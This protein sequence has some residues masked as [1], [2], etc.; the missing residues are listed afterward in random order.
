MAVLEIPELQAQ[1]DEDQAEIKDATGQVDRTQEELDRVAGAAKRGR[2]GIHPAQPGRQRTDRGWWRNRRWTTGR[3][4]TSPPQ[5]QVAAA[6]AAL[7]IRTKPACAGAGQTASR[8]GAVRL[9][10]N[11]RSLH[12]R[13]H[14]ALR[15]PGH[16][17][18]VRYRLQHAGS[19]AGAAFPGRSIPAGDSV[20]ES[21][22]PYIRIG[23][24]VD[25][26]VPSL[27][28]SFPGQVARFSVDVEQ[29]TRTMHTEVDVPNPNGV[30][31][32]G[33]YAEA[34]LKVAE[35]NRAITVPPEA[36]NIDGDSRSVWVVDPS[37]RVE[38]RTV[39]LGVETPDDVEVLSG[40]RKA[41]WSRWAIAARCGLVSWSGR[42]W[43][44]WSATRARRV[45]SKSKA[46]VNP[47]NA[48]PCLNSPFVTPTSSSSSA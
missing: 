33:M 14:Q 19:A 44:S 26:R 4:R 46:G 2:S 18:A 31:L 7:A 16:V 37:G 25:V 39:I 34:T 10:Q 35:R 6:R 21:Y 48:K 43:C 45:R 40:L 47:R 22:V 36:V 9:L 8:P 29:D 41:T 27:N 23:D 3:A 5:A 1:L 13:G 38:E 11:H 30:L 20:P 32:P 17:D 12:W 42:S 28:R 15:E 24:P